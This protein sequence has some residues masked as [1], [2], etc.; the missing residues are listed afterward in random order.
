M[1]PKGFTFFEI[2]TVFPE[3]P[4]H[5]SEAQK[6]GGFAPMGEISFRN[7]NLKA[8]PPPNSK[9]KFQCSDAKPQILER[10]LKTKFHL[11]DNRLFS[12]T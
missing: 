10:P 9:T 3:P 1:A 5:R 6:I 7:A 8:L 12:R 2:F 11:A 4:F